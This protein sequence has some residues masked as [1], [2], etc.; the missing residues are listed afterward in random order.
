MMKNGRK[1]G[2]VDVPKAGA[3]APG[4]SFLGS[5]VTDLG[6]AST[7]TRGCMGLLT[8]AVCTLIPEGIERD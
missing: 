1:R 6:V 5:G 8:D 2:D 4:R 7:Q 3:N